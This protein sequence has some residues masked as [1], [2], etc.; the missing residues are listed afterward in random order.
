MAPEH[1]LGETRVLDLSALLPGPYCSRILADFGAEVIKIERPGGGDRT[2]SVPPVRDGESLLFRLLNHGKKSITLDLK[3]REGREAFLRLV[4]A[5]DVL[6]ESFR[7]G[8]M[9]RLGLGD[10]SLRGA[11][12]RL[13][14]CALSGYGQAGPYRGRAGHDLNYVGLSGLLVLTGQEEE[15]PV[16]LGAPVADLAGGLWAAIGILLAL[17]ARGL[18]GAGRRVDTSLLGAAV[19]CLPVALA[20][21]MGKEPVRRGVGALTGGLACYHVYRCKDDGFITLAALEPEFWAA[22]CRAVEREDLLGGQY[23]PAV[24]GEPTFDSLRALFE[25]RTRQEWTTYL[26][27]VDCCSEPVYTIEEALSSPPVMALGMIRGASLLPPVDVSTLAA[28]AGPSADTVGRAPQLG[29][30]TDA[31]LQDV[32]GYTPE[33]V[34]ELREKGVV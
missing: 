12:P 26:S 17:H 5:A 30:H 25:T 32:C 7:P 6:L 21:L 19:S 33:E 9:E 27:G 31:I 10:G 3:S 1:A 4:G 11:N 24:T 28:P 29:E 22:F 13:I 15:M 14:H 18:D 2:R 23:A 20:G 34:Q 16:L 8:V